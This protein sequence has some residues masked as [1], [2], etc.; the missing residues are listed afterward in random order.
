M[1]NRPYKEMRTSARRVLPRD[2]SFFSMLPYVV[3]VNDEVVR[4]RDNALMISLEVRGP[5]GITTSPSD[6]DA[7]RRQFAQVIDGLDEEF[8][9]YVH[10][11]MRRSDLGLKP[12]LGDS[13]A[14]DVDQA[15]TSHLD[16]QNLHEFVVVI[17]IVRSVTHP[18]RLPFFKR[19]AS[20]MFQEDTKGR[21]DGLLQVADAIE[22]AMSVKARRMKISDGSLLGFYSAINTAVVR[23][24]YR[25]RMT[26]IA[27]DVS[28]V[29]VKIEKNSI[30]IEEG[31]DRPRFAAC[32]AIWRYSNETWPGMLDALNC[33]SDTVICH[34][35]TPIAQ[36]K[37]A[38]RVKMRVGQ[39]QAAGD[40]A[41][42]IMNQLLE[43]ADAVESGGQSVGLHQ[44]TVTIFADSQAELDARVSRLRGLAEQA[45]T[46]LT[47]C[48]HSLEAT[49]F[50]THPGNMDFQ[51]WE[52]AVSTTTFADMASLHMA[53]AGTRAKDLYLQTPIAV[54]MTAA[55]TT[56]RFSFQEPGRPDG[57]PPLGHTLFLG[58]SN[59]GKTTLAAFLATCTKRANARNIF[60]DRDQGLRTVV[61][62]LG[63]QYAQV[64]AGQPTGLNPLLTENGARGEAWLMDWLSALVT[65][66][67][68]VLTPMQTRVL[69]SAISQILAAPAELRNFKAFQQLFGDAADGRD[70]AMHIAEWAPGGR[71]GWVFEQAERP[72]VDFGSGSV[73]GIDMTEVLKMPT[74]RTAI[75]SYFL[76]RM[77]LMFED[78]VP[79]F[80][81]I[82]EAHSLL[83]DDYFVTRLPEYLATVRKKNVVF[84]VMT[85]HPNQIK[86]SKAKGILEGLPNRLIFPNP[87]ARADHYDSYNLS[88]SALAFILGHH[89]ERY[90]AYYEG[91][92][93]STI[94]DVDLSALGPLLTALGGI[95]SAETT[96]GANYLTKPDFWRTNHV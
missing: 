84:V 19:A 63:G 67:T 48:T 81:W 82:D 54:L 91:P 2:P 65:T 1:F 21:L 13:F 76:R 68:R 55:G 90:R 9:F 58:P 83:N 44:L 14:A 30:L 12:I 8:T 41:P 32:L 49:F 61:T 29:S 69:K 71:R 64:Y 79:T 77:E 95:S 57:E 62:A 59:S 22:R 52:M 34:S 93:G 36:H 86:E 3:E 7:L 85:Q 15:W 94:L 37:I 88:E 38:E 70:L 46:R 96:F 47:R 74:E 20:R 23:S 60:F 80:V 10:R 28:N 43:T 78:M 45:K 72:I 25:G 50:A 26:L 66:P 51:C 73:I 40:L 11:L 6:L 87:K 39:M 31:F 56:H 75:L 24:E 35:F 42:T 4:S 18:I 89:N 92:T 16:H 17:T 33:A 27:E 5:D 53:D